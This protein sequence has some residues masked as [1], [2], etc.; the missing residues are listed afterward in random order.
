MLA[1]TPALAWV[2]FGLGLPWSLAILPRKDWRDRVLVII[3]ALALGPL[4]LTIW[5]FILGTAGSAEQPL[6]RLTC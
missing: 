1:A 6:L 2:F 5:M 3:L 4:L